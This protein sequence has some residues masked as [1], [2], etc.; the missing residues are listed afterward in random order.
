MLERAHQR[1]LDAGDAAARRADARAGSACSSWSA[2]RS[3]A[4]PAG[5]AARERLVE[6]EPGDCVEQGY[7][8]MPV[9]VSARG[10]AA[11]PRRPPPSPA[12]RRRSASASATRTCS[13]SRCTVQG[14]FLVRSGRVDGRPAAARRG[15]GRGDH[16]RALADRQRA[17][18]LRR[19]HRAARPP[20]SRAARASG[21][22]RWRAGASASRT[23]SRSAAAATCTG[24]RSCSSRAPGRTRSRR[25]A[26]PRAAPRWAITARAL[27]GGGLHAGRGAPPARRARRR[28]RRPTARR[29]GTGASR[30][31]AWRCCAWRRATSTRRSPRSAACS[32]R[33][34]TPA[35]RAAA[36]AR[37]RRDH[38]RRRRR[39]GARERMRRAGAASRP[40]T[41]S[42][43]SARSSPQAR[44][45]VE[46]AAGDAGAALLGAAPG[47]ARVGG[48]R[49]ARTRRRACARSSARRAGRSATRTRPRSSSTRPARAFA[50][51]RAAPDLARARALAPAPAPASASGL[52]ARELQVL[53]LSRP[54][55]R[56][57]RSPPSSCSASGRSTAT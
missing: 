46:L 10:D 11:I 42:A 33:R 8:L 19:D 40:A 20:T 53:R 52:T 16:R 2:A 45:A 57:R 49:G 38:A 56:T 35:D 41:R 12:R 25:R 21:R 5:S 26:A 22:R 34:P 37:L 39:G 4:G 6:R 51:A 1:H 32:A 13:R 15:D 7:L 3:A 43:C 31:P 14:H 9:R 18:L 54:G 50:R 55:G 47:V 17:R 30:S 44:G 48:D 36:A 29:A 23:W 27:G 24:P 28:P